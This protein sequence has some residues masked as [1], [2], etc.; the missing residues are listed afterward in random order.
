MK[1]AIVL[2]LILFI[3]ILFF[4]FRKMEY[5]RE[6]KNILYVMPDIKIAEYDSESIRTGGVGTSGTHTSSIVIAEGL[7]KKGHTVTFFDP[8]VKPGINRGVKYINSKDDIDYDHTDTLINVSHG[9]HQFPK[10]FKNLKKLIIVFH[11]VL[12]NIDQIYSNIKAKEREYVFVSQW[13]KDACKSKEGKVIYNP[14][15]D[16]MLPPTVNEE[17]PDN[18]FIW[19]ASYKRGGEVSKKVSQKL[20]GTFVSMSYT[21]EKDTQPADKKT[22]FE[23]QNNSKYF[24][25]PLVSHEDS[26]VHKD[27]FAC[28]VAES[29]CMGVHV[30]TWPIACMNELYGEGKGCHF[31][32][33]PDNFNKDA[34][35]SY[36]LLPEPNL[37]SD[38]AIDCIIETVKSVDNQKVDVD[39]WREKFKSSKIIEQWNYIL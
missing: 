11:I 33:I 23:I 3:I 24:V 35:E 25:Y 14:V 32:K 20:G 16:D 5:M 9:E 12:P 13:T 7:A 26:I 6:S 31:I 28:C 15:M 38:Q 10:E 21:G 29:L 19:I 22:I 36:D 17:K 8:Y 18:S 2:F 34:L 30:I 37:L 39:Y 1:T 4:V 27:T